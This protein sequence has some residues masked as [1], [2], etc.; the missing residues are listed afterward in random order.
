[1]KYTS[2][3]LAGVLLEHRQLQTSV[4]SENH[5]A[6]DLLEVVVEV[7]YANKCHESST[8]QQSHVQTNPVIIISDLSQSSPLGDNDDITFR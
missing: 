4:S 5:Y 8:Q 2:R 6:W 3:S 1:M 7:P